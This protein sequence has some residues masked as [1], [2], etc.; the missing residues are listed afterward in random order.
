MN[1]L[2]ALRQGTIEMLGLNEFQGRVQSGNESSRPPATNAFIEQGRKDYR[3]TLGREQTRLKWHYLRLSE[4]TRR[5]EKHVY[6]WR[7]RIEVKFQV[8]FPALH[9]RI[10]LFYSFICYIASVKDQI[11]SV[12]CFTRRVGELQV[13]VR[14]SGVTWAVWYS[15]SRVGPAL[16]PE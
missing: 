13:P 6:A 15:I 2:V 5:G 12:P 3:E 1:E 11:H 8:Q 7:Q 4:G 9:I 16:S 14:I 10:L